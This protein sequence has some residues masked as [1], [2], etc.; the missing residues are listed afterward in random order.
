MLN[1]YRQYLGC[2]SSWFGINDK[3]D[4]G[5]RFWLYA[6]D[7]FRKY[8]RAISYEDKKG[9]TITNAFQKIWH[10]SNFKPNKK[11]VVKGSGFS[12]RLMKL[13]LVKM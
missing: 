1:S 12:N 4:K 6:L 11:G 5:I 8:A 3:F 9:T 13:W 2:R 10:E 7:I